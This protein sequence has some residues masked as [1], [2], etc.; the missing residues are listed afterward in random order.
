MNKNTELENY[1]ILVVNAGSS[2]LK[3]SLVKM[4]EE[5]IIANGLVGRIGLGLSE[6]K[7]TK[8]SQKM[9]GELK[10][11]N[12]SEAFNLMIN[13]LLE[14]KAINNLNEIGAIGNRVLHGTSKYKSSVII[15]DEVLND[16]KDYTCL[17]PLH[18]PGEL[19]GIEGGKKALPD[20][21]QVATFDTAFHQTI[22]SI[23]Y[24]YPVPDEWYDEYKVRKYGFHGTS[25]RY[26]TETMQNILGKREVNIIS[27]HIGSGASIAAIKNG[28]SYDT[29]MGLTPLAGLMM[30]TR[31]GSVD[32]SI[33]EY[34][35]RRS[36]KNIEEIMDDLNKKSGLVGMAG[37]SDWRDVEEN[38]KNGDIKAKLAI[39][40]ITE[41]AANYIWQYV[42]EL[43]GRVD[44]IVF[45]AGIGENA[46]YYRFKVIE[47]LRL[48]NIKVSEEE[49]NKIAG[50]KD[51][52]QG[53]ISTRDSSIPVYVIPTNEEIMIARETY[54][55]T[56][57]KVLKK[58][59]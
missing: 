41:S 34:V 7:L 58:T 16:I 33:I 45:T 9:S 13:K 10:I 17:G 42:R 53:I 49:N 25:H 3:F 37:F 47:K 28:K 50:F 35:A 44:A 39:E 19:L 30:C 51:V 8:N 6:W 57:E 22:P 55:L 23:N 38:A 46:S 12:H 59:R 36:G 52:K 11:A 15:N 2:S 20:A 32:P 26:I 27:C 5:T 1:K 31:S 40:M 21:I 54:D 18:H 43:D 29:T 56:K 14:V 4:P 24:C 48:L